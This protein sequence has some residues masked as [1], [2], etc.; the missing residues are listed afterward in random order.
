MSDKM[1]EKLTKLVSRR[2]ILASLSAGA[3]AL[4]SSLLG[5]PKVSAAIVPIECCVLCNS[6][7][8]TCTGCRCSWSWTC[9][10]GNGTFRCIEC[11][12]VSFPCNGTCTNVSCSQIVSV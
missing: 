8:A 4:A 9:R 6:P 10:N 2:G 12:F 3:V 7:S 11:Y 1:V 5:T